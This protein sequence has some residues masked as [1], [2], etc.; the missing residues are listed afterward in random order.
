M[1]PLYC[2]SYML[3][4]RP[5]HVDV[6]WLQIYFLYEVYSNMCELVTCES[7]FHW[8]KIQLAITIEI[9]RYEHTDWVLQK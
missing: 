5:V 7:A 8:I 1:L 2:F 6:K 4:Y 3:I 9:L